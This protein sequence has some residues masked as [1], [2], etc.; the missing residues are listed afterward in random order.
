MAK[1]KASQNRWE[2][3]VNAPR[4]LITDFKKAGVVKKLRPGAVLFR[5]G[6]PARGAFL[7]RKGSVRLTLAAGK[8]PLH[9]R[10]VGPG[11]LLG[12]PGT[13]GN[14]KYNF[15]AEALTGCEVIYVRRT[16]LLKALRESGEVCLHIVQVLG[17]ELLSLAGPKAADTHAK[18]RAASL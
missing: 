16:A 3:A 15:T 11:Y 2:Q 8:E 7:L 1:R 9:S 14:H 12:L 18:L 13:L 6:S 5:Q 17:G 4:S 10:T